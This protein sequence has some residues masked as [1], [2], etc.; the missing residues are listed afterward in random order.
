MARIDRVR[1]HAVDELLP[2]EEVIAAAN[3]TPKGMWRFVAPIAGIGA[4][5]G[6][7][8]ATSTADSMLS[9]ALGGGIGGGLGAAL[10][11]IAGGLRY[12]NSPALGG[13]YTTLARTTERL[14]VFRRAGATNRIKELIS[15]FPLSE[16]T[17][18]VDTSTRIAPHPILVTL[19]DGT[20]HGL[21]A[22]KI[23]RPQR[24]IP[25]SE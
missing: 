17:I 22:A 1:A 6:Y 9:A 11:V 14:L 3:T 23:E 2:A 24:L 8:I 25:G 20:I 16:V 19:P 4:G 7:L 13:L 18:E 10:G 12:R 21:E 15:A 5:V